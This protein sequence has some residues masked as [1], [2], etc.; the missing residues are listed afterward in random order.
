MSKYTTEVRFIC[1]SLAND[2][3]VNDV[4]NIIANSI[5]KI[6]DFNFPIFDEQYRKILET[7]ILKHYYTREIGEETVGLWKLRL[8]TRLNEIMPYYNKL[9]ESELLEFNPLYTKY[10]I[11]NGNNKGVGNSTDTNSH[12]DVTTRTD[13]TTSVSNTS[14]NTKN[15]YSDTPQ[16]S[17]KNI[18]VVENAYL[19]NATVINNN[20]NGSIKNTGTVKNDNSGSYKL[21]KNFTDTNEYAETIEGYDGTSPSR[22]VSE[23]REILINIDVMII[24]ELEDLFINLW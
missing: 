6:F 5:D 10:V 18:D 21:D 16:G 24:D 14:N 13:D 7:K 15:L 3:D 11:K 8:N 4:E 23:F 9:Y 22:L 20:E 12:N 17:I 2:I 1:Q 19:T